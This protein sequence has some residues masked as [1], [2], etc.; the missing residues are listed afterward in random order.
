MFKAGLAESLSGYLRKLL[1]KLH[2]TFYQLGYEP[3]SPMLLLPMSRSKQTK[4]LRRI[5]PI[6]YDINKY[7]WPFWIKHIYFIFE[8]VYLHA[9]EL[10]NFFFEESFSDATLTIVLTRRRFFAVLLLSF[11]TIKFV[12]RIECFTRHDIN[13]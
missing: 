2:F 8:K 3:L 13:F 9:K 5:D 12:T 6:S 1:T 11:C 10:I 7:I 4:R